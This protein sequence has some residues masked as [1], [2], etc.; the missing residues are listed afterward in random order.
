MSVVNAVNLWYSS[1]A[2]SRALA[3]YGRVTSHLQRYIE[4]PYFSKRT[5]QK[6]VMQFYT[7]V[8]DT[9]GKNNPL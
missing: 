3:S 1:K 9:A 5:I 2:T 4:S 7:T 8:H 6:P